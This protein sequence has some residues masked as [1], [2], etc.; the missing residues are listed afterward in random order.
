MSVD[1]RYNRLANDIGTDFKKKG[2]AT[3]LYSF[4]CGACGYKNV[5]D[6]SALVCGCG[7]ELKGRLVFH[8]VG[9]TAIYDTRK[10]GA[11]R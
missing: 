10:K 11:R 6:V 9:D 8:K 2:K 5:H 1:D 4:H 7:N 3:E